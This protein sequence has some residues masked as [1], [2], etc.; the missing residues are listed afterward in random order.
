MELQAGEWGPLGWDI[1]LKAK[2]LSSRLGFGP[3][4]WNSRPKC[5]G[6]RGG[7]EEG[8]NFAYVRLGFW[9]QRGGGDLGEARGGD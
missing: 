5:G 6:W 1:S 9:P 2:I 4:G 8:E 3:Q 7:E